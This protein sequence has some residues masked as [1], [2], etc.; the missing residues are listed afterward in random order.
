[1]PAR[2]L[3]GSHPLPSC[4]P[5]NTKLSSSELAFTDALGYCLHHVQCSQQ[6]GSTLRDTCAGNGP[7]GLALARWTWR[8]SFETL[9]AHKPLRSICKEPAKNRANIGSEAQQ[10]PG[11]VCFLENKNESH[12]SRCR[13][14]ATNTSK[15]GESGPSSLVST[16]LRGGGCEACAP[17]MSGRM[18]I[19]G[20][21]IRM[22][23]VAVLSEVMS[24]RRSQCTPALTPRLQ[25]D[26]TTLHLLADGADWRLGGTD[27]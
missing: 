26:P 24:S 6:A 17:L 15:N 5:G 18:H 10:L 27:C 12:P 14:C 19:T 1:M 3:C 4:G 22:R 20:A 13:T 16:T 7:P 21:H 23:S 2:P 8:Q 9:P 11:V 25:F